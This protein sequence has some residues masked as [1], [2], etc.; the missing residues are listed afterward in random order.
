[1]APALPMN[2]REMRRSQVGRPKDA[3]DFIF[4]H[5]LY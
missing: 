5:K 4:P 3:S 1:L 2:R